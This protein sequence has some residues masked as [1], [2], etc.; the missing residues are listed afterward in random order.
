[1]GNDGASDSRNP[2]PHIRFEAEQLPLRMV[3]PQ[4]WPLLRS[5]AR[6]FAFLLPCRGVFADQAMRITAIITAASSNSTTG[7]VSMG[8]SLRAVAV[9][10][11]SLP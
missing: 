2:R 9:F 4:Y 8:V 5:R 1:M 7:S 10:Q 11:I 3:T 6:F